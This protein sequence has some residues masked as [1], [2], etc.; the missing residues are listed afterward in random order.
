[1]KL[2]GNILWLIFGG[3]IVAGLYFLGGILLCC[4]IIGIP[5][6]VEAMKMG[7]VALLPFGTEVELDPAKGCLTIGFNVLWILLSGWE[8]VLTH[9]IFGCIL[10]ITIIGIPFGKQHFKLARYAIFPFGAHITYGSK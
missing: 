10:C 9:V 3:L 4:T 5:F 2:I 1:M 6:G 8:I 7:L